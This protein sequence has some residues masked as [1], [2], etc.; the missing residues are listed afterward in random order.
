MRSAEVPKADYWRSIFGIILLPVTIVQASQVGTGG[1]RVTFWTY[2]LTL[3][4]R[5]QSLD[6]PQQDTQFRQLSLSCCPPLFKPPLTTN[7]Q[8]GY[9]QKKQ[10]INS[11]YALQMDTAQGWS[12]AKSGQLGISHFLDDKILQGDSGSLPEYKN[13]LNSSSE[14]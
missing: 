13:N 8:F 12:S 14:V 2:D 10:A 6:F 3:T 11:Q 7:F 4:I 5:V 1:T 9:Y